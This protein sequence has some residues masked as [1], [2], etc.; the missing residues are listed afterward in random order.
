MRY[1]TELLS[2][3]WDFRYRVDA[4]RGHGFNLLVAHAPAG[5]SAHA[6]PA[7]VATL[8]LQIK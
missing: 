3:R 2:V 1:K 7:G 8:S 6:F 5:L 4:F